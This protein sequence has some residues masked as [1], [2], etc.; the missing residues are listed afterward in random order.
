[1][2]MLTLWT[3]P[4]S[5]NA[6]K[7]SFLLGELGL[8]FEQR[9]V[10]LARPRP[11]AYLALNPV[12]GL[13]LLQDD[14]FLLAESQAILR[15]LAAR[16]GRDDLYP[17]DPRDRARVDEFLDRF[18]TGLRTQLFRRE[19][20]MLGWTAAQGFRAEDA[21]P[22]AAPAIEAEIQ[23]AIALLD[24][25]VGERGAVLDRFTIAD[26]ALAPVL[27]R[28]RDTGLDL[29]P[30]PRLAA[31]SDRLLARPAWA[32]LHAAGAR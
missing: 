15:Y 4:W 26:C 11:A 29:S 8:G 24:G 9:I 27:A 31:L 30:F 17:A 1:M 28:A 7:V 14:D 21:D 12:G 2:R 19:L 22:D 13:P 18:A 3:N 5:S 10:S 23:P 16:A 32:A 6:Q 25:L 20:V